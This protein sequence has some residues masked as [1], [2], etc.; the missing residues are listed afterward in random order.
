MINYNIA[1]YLE[2][3]PEWQDLE[4]H[5]RGEVAT[6]SV[7][8]DIDYHDEKAA[9]IEGRARQLA[10]QKLEKILE[11][12]YTTTQPPVDKAENTHKKVGL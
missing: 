6:L 8:D 4:R 1:K 3:S 11:P 10:K 9:A 7:N 12:F 2:S 5:I